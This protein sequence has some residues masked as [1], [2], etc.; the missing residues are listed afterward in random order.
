MTTKIKWRLSKLPSVDEVA[1]LVTQKVL[2]NEEA[3]EILFSLETDEDRDKVSLQEEIKF[4]RELVSKLS[5]S[6]TIVEQ[7]R[8]IEK[9]YQSQSWYPA[10]QTFVAG[11][12]N[13]LSND[14]LLTYNTAS[15]TQQSTYSVLGA[16]SNTTGI[17]FNTEPTPQFTDIKTF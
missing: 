14:S 10:Y 15:G 1:L 12:T 2:T 9:P 4:L 8:Y 3:R 17:S 16:S 13:S 11:T 6:R 5:T 7:I